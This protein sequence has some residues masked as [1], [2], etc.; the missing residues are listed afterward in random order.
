MNNDFQNYKMD[1]E[2]M[3]TLYQ[4]S[5]ANKDYRINELEKTLT[6]LRSATTLDKINTERH[7]MELKSDLFNSNKKCEE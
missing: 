7:I 2:K 4:E 6:D 1:S 3:C 5:I